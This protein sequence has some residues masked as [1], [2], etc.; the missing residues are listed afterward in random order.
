VPWRTDRIVPGVA[1]GAIQAGGWAG[2]APLARLN[3]SIPK[4][5]RYT[6]KGDVAVIGRLHGV[7]N[8]RWLGPLGRQGGLIAWAMWLAIHIFYLIG[9]TNR[10]VVMLRWGWNFFTSGRG[11]RL[12]TGK[13]LL[14]NI[15]EPAA[16]AGSVKVAPS[17]DESADA[18]ASA[19]SD[20]AGTRGRSSRR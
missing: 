5:F 2:R 11:T 15:E 6:D 9:L 7:T 4:P 16:P 14:P 13:P 19:T 20:H 10:I 3:G 17:A 18:A 1:Q 8:I 12:I